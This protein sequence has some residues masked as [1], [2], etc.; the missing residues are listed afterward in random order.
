MA[1]ECRNIKG[2]TSDD[3]AGRQGR[4]WTVQEGMGGNA[5]VGQGS[6]EP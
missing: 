5:W 6:T 1:S 4:V 2:E 3:E